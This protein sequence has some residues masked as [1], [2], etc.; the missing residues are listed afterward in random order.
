MRYSNELLVTS[1]D[2]NTGKLTVNTHQIDYKTQY[3]CANIAD[4]LND[5]RQNAYHM[6]I[7]FV[8]DCNSFSIT[9]QMPDYIILEVYCVFRGMAR[10]NGMHRIAKMIQSEVAERMIERIAKDA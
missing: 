5:V 8:K 7:H 10:C 6:S 9:A 4:V 3:H 2:C 1:Y